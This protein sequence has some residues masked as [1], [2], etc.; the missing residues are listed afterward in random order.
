MPDCYQVRDA[1]VWAG[2]KLLETPEEETIFQLW[3]MDY[4]LPPQRS[5]YYD[6]RFGEAPAVEF[7]PVPVQVG[8]FG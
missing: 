1:R 8:L 4:V 5:D 6:P 7:E 3:G 2:A